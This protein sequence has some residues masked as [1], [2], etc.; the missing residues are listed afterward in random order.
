[1]LKIKNLTITLSGDKSKSI[2]TELNLEFDKGYTYFLT[3]R[4]GS[5]KSTLVNTIMGNPEF[6]IYSGTIEII[7]EQY[8][9]HIF[10]KVKDE[11]VENDINVRELDIP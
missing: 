2:I 8:E 7:N 5:G 11:C 3:G 4:N 10:E 9:E 1:M 6:S